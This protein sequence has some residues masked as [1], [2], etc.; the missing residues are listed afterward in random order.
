LQDTQSTLDKRN[1]VVD[2][3]EAEFVMWLLGSWYV[4][5]LLGFDGTEPGLF[6]CDSRTFE[7]AQQPTTS[8]LLSR[9]A[10]LIKSRMPSTC[11]AEGSCYL[12]LQ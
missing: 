5:L 1:D 2:Y 4:Y 6:G 12:H 3:C 9:T 11:Q 7:M 8:F 10:Q